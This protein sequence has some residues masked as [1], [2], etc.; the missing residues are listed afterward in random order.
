M[1]RSQ[2]WLLSHKGH[3]GK[4]CLIWPFSCCT[5][6]YGQ[7][8]ADGRSQMA[9]RYMCILVHGEPPKDHETAHSCGNRRCVNPRH[10][11][12]KTKTDNQLD[13]NSQGTSKTHI[14][15]WVLTPKQVAAIRKS[16]AKS[17]VLAARYGVTESNIRLI[18]AGKIWRTGKYEVGGFGHPNHPQNR[19]HG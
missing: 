12:W 6:G 4:E 11:S 7:C 18:R 13:R 5:P 14:G 9:H 19:V 10:L 8:Y 1:S 15:R 2:D 3:K 17:P 16:K